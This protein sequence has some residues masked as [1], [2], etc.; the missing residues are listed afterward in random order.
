MIGAPVALLTLRLWFATLG[1]VRLQYNDVD[2]RTYRD[3]VLWMAHGHPL[4]SFYGHPENHTLGFTY[5]PFAAVVMHPLGWI[6]AT[7]AYLW[8][9]VAIVV[10]LAVCV[11]WILPAE[12]LRPANWWLAICAGVALFYLNPIRDTFSFGQVDVFVALA[13]LADLHLLRRGSRWAGTGIGVATAFKLTPGIFILYLLVTRRTRAAVTA[14]AA[15]LVVTGLSTAIAPGTSRTY[16]LT[17]IWQ[18]DRIGQIRSSSNQS[19]YGLLTHLADN[20]VSPTAHAPAG[21]WLIGGVVIAAV[22]LLLARKAFTV[23]DDLAGFTLAGLVGGLVSPISWVHHLF[24]FAPAC[25]I[26]ADIAIRQRRWTVGVA[27]AAL[28]VAAVSS[29]VVNNRHPGGHHY[30]GGLPGFL[31]ENA[32]AISAIALVLWLPARPPTGT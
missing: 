18:P 32:F 3:A 23:G 31:A 12:L 21:L 14:M 6:S 19:L 13:V 28:Y 27:V 17:V 9:S 26:L 7:H 16:W 11:R 2:L 29:L 1:H 25:V 10:A 22:G 30:V 24:W 8:W 15:A 4:Y 5:P 20:D